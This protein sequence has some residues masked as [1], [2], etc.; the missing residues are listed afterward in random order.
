M[1][2]S[3]MG[4][5]DFTVEQS[6][7]PHRRRREHFDLHAAQARVGCFSKTQLLLKV[8]GLCHVRLPLNYK[9]LKHMVV[10][11]DNSHRWLY[12]RSLRTELE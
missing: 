6:D 4:P 1:V 3:P 2:R 12:I 7:F 11:P 5:N 9:K 8:F 10:H